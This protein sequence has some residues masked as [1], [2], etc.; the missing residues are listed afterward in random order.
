ME[1]ILKKYHPDREA[2]EPPAGAVSPVGGIQA[3]ERNDQQG[4]SRA[5]S[6][7]ATR[8]YGGP[9]EIQ[10]MSPPVSRPPIDGQAR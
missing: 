6:G 8:L 3:S 4:K 1:A 9:R 7:G 2:A 5:R 10:E